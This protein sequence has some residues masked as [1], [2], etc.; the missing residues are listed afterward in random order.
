M[1][2]AGHFFHW[3]S[4]VPVVGGAVWSRRRLRGSIIRPRGW[5]HCLRPGVDR[6][7]GSVV[8]SAS[9]LFAL[10]VAEPTWRDLFGFLRR[11]GLFRRAGNPEF[12]RATTTIYCGK[13]IGMFGLGGTGGDRTSVAAWGRAIP[14]DDVIRKIDR[15]SRRVVAAGE[16]N[17]RSVR[18]GRKHRDF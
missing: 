2:R 13:P 8:S 5:L 15:R 12:I 4:Q 16:R 3:D 10:S 1:P 14:A 7:D 11:I 17:Q 18:P 6:G 9:G